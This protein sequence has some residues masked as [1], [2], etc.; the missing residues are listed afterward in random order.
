MRSEDVLE[1]GG[2][3]RLPRWVWAIAAVAAGAVLLGVV[4]TFAGLHHGAA[5]A[6]VGRHIAQAGGGTCAPA[7]LG[8]GQVRTSAGMPFVAQ[9]LAGIPVKVLAG[10]TGSRTV[11]LGSFVLE[12]SWLPGEGGLVRIWSPT[13]APAM[14]CW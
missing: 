13:G 12:P 11:V 8:P 9:T 4:V 10:G 5:S 1:F 7:V 2:W 6:S 3:P 14:S